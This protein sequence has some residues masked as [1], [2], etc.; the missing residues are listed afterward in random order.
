MIIELLN[1]P[2]NHTGGVHNKLYN[3]EEAI[4]IE[5]YETN[6][7]ITL[8]EEEVMAKIKKLKNRKALWTDLIPNELLKYAGPE[9]GKHLKI[10]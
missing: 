3:T 7:Q 1:S 6:Y 8:S 5:N 2:D 9:L 10:L 4:S